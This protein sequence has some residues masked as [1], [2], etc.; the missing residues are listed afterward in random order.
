MAEEGSLSEAEAL[1]IALKDHPEFQQAFEDG[2]L[3]E[4]ILDENG[5]TVNPQL[6]LTAHVIIER[7]LAEDKPKGVAAVA[8]ELEELGLSRHEIR[9]EMARPATGQIWYMMKEGCDF[10]EKRYLD[11][12]W[13]VVESLR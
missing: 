6:H 7:Q 11:E 2:T 1:Q 9:H 8:R 5:D 3:P 4:E 12:L 13:E 10:D